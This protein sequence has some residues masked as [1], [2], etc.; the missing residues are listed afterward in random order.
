MIS[1]FLRLLSCD[2][3][4][5]RCRLAAS[6]K[7]TLCI[8]LIILFL[9]KHL[10][11]HGVLGFWGATLGVTGLTTTKNLVVF[12]TVG[13]GTTNPLQKFQIGVANTL[14]VSTDGKVF[15]VTADAKVGIGTTNPTVK[16]DVRGDAYIKDDLTVDGGDVTSNNTSLNL[17]NTN[18]TTANVLGA[19]TAIIIGATTGITTIRNNL[20]V[21]GD[22][23]VGGNDIQASTGATAITLSGANVSIGGTLTVTGNDIKS[24]TATAITLSDANVTAKGNLTVDGDTTLGNAAGDTVSFGGNVGT[25]ITPSANNTHDLGSETLKWGT[26]FATSFNGDITGNADTA[27][28]LATERNIAITG[29]LSWN[30]NFDG[31]ANVTAAGT[32][33]NS[34][35]T[36]GTYGSATQVGIVTVDN[37]GRIT[38]A[39]NIPIDFGFGNATV[40]QA[41]KLTTPKQIDIS[42][43]VIGVGIGT[44]FDGT[45]NVTIPTELNTTGVTAGTYGSATQVGIVTV[46]AK[47]RITAAS[48][49]PISI[50]GASLTSI[51]AANQVLH[52]NSGNTEVVGSAG[53]IYDGTAL[54]VGIANTT[55]SI[56]GDA[57]SNIELGLGATNN[58]T[59]IDF[60]GS[61]HDDYSAR[62]IRHPGLNGNFTITNKGTGNIN[63]ETTVLNVSGDIRLSAA[64]PE[65]EFNVGGARL[66]GL[67][68]ALSIHTGGGLN[69]SSDEV[70]RINSTGVGIGITIPTSKLH[71]NGTIISS[72]G[73]LGSNGNGTRYISTE[74]PTGGSD[75]DVWYQITS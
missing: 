1:A 65:I 49:I 18:V 39:S 24:S 32:L 47:G 37:K 61:T 29:D 31:S 34:G 21:D 51:A 27:T 13:I 15:V 55:V 71:V 50:G 64:D 40:A 5:R 8:F 74:S 4:I 12:D 52:K 46:D 60:H 2:N 53:L 28:K 35:V 62:I 26:V 57:G 22:I 73:T 54:K 75:G 9:N 20:T 14:G 17:F 41:N 58:S 66:K 68:N 23:K 56:G 3:Y 30:V 59:Y 10:K 45:Q 69:S 33:A 72:A 36:A 11:R 38:A 16:L 42:G 67:L 19:G 7:K 6:E 44:T 63:F 43:D 25:G 48:N 70:V